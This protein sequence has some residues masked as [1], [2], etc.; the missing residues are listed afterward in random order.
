MPFKHCHLP[1]PIL[2][3]LYLKD[4]I[5]CMIFLKTKTPKHLVQFLLS[6]STFI[7]ILEV[8]LQDTMQ[9]VFLLKLSKPSTLDSIHVT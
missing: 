2:R 3:I 4:E 5:L 6:H 8:P 9:Q 1:N 7:L